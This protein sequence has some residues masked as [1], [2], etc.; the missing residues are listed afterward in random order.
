MAASLTAIVPNYN[1]GRF[2]ARAI[3]ALQNQDPPPS[4]ILIIDDA[5]TDDSVA[6][7]KRLATSCPSIRLIQNGNNLGTVRSLNRGIGESRGKYVYLAAADDMVHPGFFSKALAVLEKYPEAAFTC[8]ECEI[9]NESGAV[10]AIRPP[11]RPTQHT[12]YLAPNAVKHLLR[13]IDNWGLT[14]SAILRRDLVLSVGSL[15]SHLA[16]FADGFLLRKLA[17]RHGFCFIPTIV[18]QWMAR[19]DGYSRSI[20][21][22]PRKSLELLDIACQKIMADP[23]F[24]D[25]YSDFFRRRYRFSISYI[26]AC[27]DPPNRELLNKIAVQGW[28][29][30]LV[31]DTALSFRHWGRSLAPA[32]LAVRMYPFSV[33][34]LAQTALARRVQA[35]RRN[36]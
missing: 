13:R 11:A 27:S 6:V 26:A 9:V 21:A 24:P 22:D 23:D 34:A 16:S 2:L 20:A 7:I 32:W 5:S 14:S 33:M 1:H 29:D 25:W 28:L 30:R 12:A 10:T 36:C 4:E 17:L 3:P 8:G 18:A 31:I 15:D 19:S 35:W